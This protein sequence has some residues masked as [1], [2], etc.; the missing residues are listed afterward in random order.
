MQTRSWDGQDG[1]KKYRMEIVADR[2]QFGP[3]GGS[4]SSSHDKSASAS[5]AP[6]KSASS[7]EAIQYP[8]E[9]I[10]AEDIPF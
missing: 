4:S 5:K 8:E 10:N 2:I 7:E 6:A 1:Q 9:E 3:K